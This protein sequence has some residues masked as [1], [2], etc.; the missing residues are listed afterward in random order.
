MNLADPFAPPA[1]DAVVV[2]AGRLTLDVIVRD[3][4]GGAP[5]AQAGGTCGNVLCNLATLGWQAYPLMDLGDDDPGRRFLADLARWGV[6]PDLVRRLAGEQTPVIV[7]H[8]RTTDA[9]AVHSYSSRCPSCGARL[10]YYEPVPLASVEERLPRVPAARAFFFDRDSP[11]TLLLA[12]RLAAQGALVVFEPNYAGPET[13]FQEAVE[14]AHVLKFSAD[15]LPDLGGRFSLAAPLLLVETHGADGLRYRDQRGGGDWQHLPALPAPQVR[16]A[17]GSGDW[18]TAGLIHRLGQQGLAGFR[19]AP[20]EAWREALR[21]GQ[22]LAA[23]GC[24]FEGARGAVYHGARDDFVA[25]VRDLLAG[26]TPA[27]PPGPPTFEPAGAFCPCQKGSQ[28]DEG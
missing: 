15:K 5:L 3:P 23:W 26:R 2:G 1:A 14:T 21:F 12:R 19:A 11:G 8:V 17:G 4:G 20:P 6:R 13:A 16:D 27:L 28:K 25:A 24:A 7:H 10:R 22:A 18:C 9:G